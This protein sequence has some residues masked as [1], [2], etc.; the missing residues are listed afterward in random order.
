MLLEFVVFMPSPGTRLSGC[1]VVA[2]SLDDREGGGMRDMQ[3]MVRSIRI[4]KSAVNNNK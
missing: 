1:V 4:Q 3:N 2:T